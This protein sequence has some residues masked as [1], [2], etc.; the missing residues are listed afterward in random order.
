[1]VF[2]EFS[3]NSMSVNRYGDIVHECWYKLVE[4]YSNIKLD[5]FTIMPDNVHGII[6]LKDMNNSRSNVRAGLKPAPTKPHPLSEIIHGFKT[7]S[8]RRINELRKTPGL[9]VW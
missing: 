1:M 9:P 4:H 3:D 6:T 8:A 5:S 7:F 2:G